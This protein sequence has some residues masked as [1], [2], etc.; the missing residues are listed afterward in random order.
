MAALPLTCVLRAFICHHQ[1][2]SS[3]HQPPSIITIIIIII[4]IIINHQ[5]SIIIIIRHHSSQSGVRLCVLQPQII[6]AGPG[7]PFPTS[8][9]ELQRAAATVLV[10]TAAAVPAH[11]ASRFAFFDLVLFCLTFEGL[12]CIRRHTFFK[13]RCCLKF[14]FN[15]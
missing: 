1:V 10:V 15:F 7:P 11:A 13:S 5:S 14:I 12:V 8:R 6:V 4:I 2:S 9:Q 3:P